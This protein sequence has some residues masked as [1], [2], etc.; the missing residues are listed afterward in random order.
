M[1]KIKVSEEFTDSPGA[2]DI[3]DGEY[4]GEE[5]YNSLLRAKF[6]LAQQKGV[7]LFIDLDDTWGYASSFIS[8]AFGRLADEFGASTSFD[9]LEL[10]SNDDPTLFDKI[11]V[12]LNKSDNKN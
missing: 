10:K 6:I 8:G 2:R 4:S 3:T 7:K 5:F 12:E 11:K 1:E 9:G